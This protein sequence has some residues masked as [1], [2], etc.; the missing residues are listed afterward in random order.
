VREVPTKHVDVDRNLWAE[1][2]CG[3]APRDLRDAETLE[4][5]RDLAE[6]HRLTYVAATRAR[7]LLVV[8]VVGDEPLA[9][10]PADGE[11]WLDTLRPV[12]Y[13]A[14]AARGEAEP[15]PGVPE[16]GK[17]SVVD[18]PADAKRLAARPVAPGLHHPARGSHR[19]VWWDPNRLELDTA[20]RPDQDQFHVLAT[21]RG[22][23]AAEAGEIA[24]AA[25]RSVRSLTLTAGARPSRR[26]TPVARLAEDPTDQPPPDVGMETTEALRAT[27]PAGLRF[28]ALVHAALESADLDADEVAVRR[29]VFTSA[30]QVGAPEDEAEAAVASVLAALRHPL[31]RRA[32]AA[33][34][35]RRETPVLVTLEDGVLAEGVLDL[36]FR[37]VDGSG[38]GRWTVVDFK[39][40]REITERRE[41]YARQ[42]DLYVRAVARATGEEAEGVLL[43]V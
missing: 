4:N 15:S 43:S 13:P 1:A 40:D 21:D 22:N 37:E 7:D 9:R 27:R 12:T 35:V 20:A 23:K 36:A 2:L 41:A 33:D 24:H 19:V 32:A 42:V 31:L 38:Q 25:W 30:R 16:F 11:L 5:A 3:C 10:P 17:D 14:D 8:P 26:V 18:R 29:V 39:T 34:E 28:G 6:A